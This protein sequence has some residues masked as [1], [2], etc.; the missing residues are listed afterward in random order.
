VAEAKFE[1]K[2]PKVPL[3]PVSAVSNAY[4]AAG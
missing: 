2:L 1:L 3:R 4:L